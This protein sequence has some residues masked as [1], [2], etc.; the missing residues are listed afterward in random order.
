MAN[1]HNTLDSTDQKS[2]ANRLDQASKQEKRQAKAEAAN[3][4]PPTRAAEKVSV[5]DSELVQRGGMNVKGKLSA[6]RR[7]D[8][9]MPFGPGGR[10]EVILPSI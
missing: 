8:L 7:H 10:K 1:S 2:I 3:R 5:F 9:H 6:P 4:E